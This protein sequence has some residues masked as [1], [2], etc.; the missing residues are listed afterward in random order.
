MIDVQYD[1]KQC[2]YND[3]WWWKP[4]VKCYTHKLVAHVFIQFPLQDTMIINVCYNF[5]LSANRLKIV[6]L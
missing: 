1:V 3:R 6:R 2:V 5:S 4:T